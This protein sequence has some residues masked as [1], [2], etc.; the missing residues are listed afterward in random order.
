LTILAGSDMLAAN[1]ER[2]EVR[3]DDRRKIPWECRY[4]KL[5]KEGRST[6][7]LLA[8][9]KRFIGLVHPLLKKDGHTTP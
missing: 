6:M 9:K 2:G 3:M 5:V 7:L 4:G 8:H 1:I